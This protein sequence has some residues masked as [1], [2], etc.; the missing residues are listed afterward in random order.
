VNYSYQKGYGLFLSNENNWWITGND[1]SIKIVDEFASIM[2][3]EEC[4]PDGLPK[5]ILYS[6][7]HNHGL[8]PSELNPPNLK[9]GWKLYSYET[10]YIWHN[11]NSGDVI[12]EFKSDITKIDKYTAMW[13]SLQPIFRQCVL[14]G[15]FPFHA[16]LIEYKGQGILLAAK[17]GTGKSTC[18]L[19]LP[20]QWKSLC[21]DEA[22]IILDNNKKY[23]VHPLPTWKNYVLN[24]YTIE[25][26]ENKFGVQYSVPLSAIFFL[27]QSEKDEVIPISSKKSP[28]LMVES[29]SQSLERERIDMPSEEKTELVKKVFNNAFDMAKVTPA[30]RLRVSLNGRFWEEIEKAIGL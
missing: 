17:G 14:M 23:Y 27:E 28:L 1:E 26:A 11:T 15:G 5:L 13:L 4:L 8:M 30:F 18:C 21:D 20:N 19:R 29:A 10:V 24:N 12:F 25:L 2:K 16:G 22:L 9:S 6:S 3:L 7:N